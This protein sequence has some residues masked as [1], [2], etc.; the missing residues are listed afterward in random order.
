MDIN[1]LRGTQSLNSGKIAQIITTNGESHVPTA[2]Q[3]AS[4]EHGVLMNIVDNQD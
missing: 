1:I 2:A 4:S 3:C